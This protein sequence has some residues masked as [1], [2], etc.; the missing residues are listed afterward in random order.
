MAASTSDRLVITYTGVPESYDGD[1]V[2]IAMVYNASAILIAMPSQNSVQIRVSES[3]DAGDYDVYT[4]TRKG[5]EDQYGFKLESS[6]LS[7]QGWKKL[8]EQ[9]L[10]RGGFA[11]RAADTAEDRW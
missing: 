9:G 4:F 10:Y 2:D 1:S 3:D 11:E 5:L 8:K 7:E 6:L